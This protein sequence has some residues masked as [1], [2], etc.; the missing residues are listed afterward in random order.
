MLGVC[1]CPISQAN[2]GVGVGVGVGVGDPTSLAF[3]LSQLPD[4]LINPAVLAWLI[5]I[6]LAMCEPA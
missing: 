5:C 3:S 1:G 4:G 2:S 6:P